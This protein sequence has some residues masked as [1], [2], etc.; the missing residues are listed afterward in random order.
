MDKL[1][2]N[3]L[4]LE[5]SRRV[6]LDELIGGDDHFRWIATREEC[7][8]LAR[9]FSLISLDK[10]QVNVRVENR[11]LD[12]ILASV[13]FSAVVVQYCV[14]SLEPLRSSVQN[15]FQL[16]ILP[17]GNRLSS[18]GDREEVIY[19]ENEE[20]SIDITDGT[21]ELGEV[22]AEYLALA[23][24]PYPRKRNTKVTFCDFSSDQSG[25]SGKASFAEL[26]KWKG[27]A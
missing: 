5:F 15:S 24:D 20:L 22:I 16:R 23:I 10:F 17:K 8:A 2:K 19:S 13:Q 7:G 18:F 11:G 4:D 14:V 26:N 27:K 25:E 1:G 3:C 6:I 9:R 12:G 21:V